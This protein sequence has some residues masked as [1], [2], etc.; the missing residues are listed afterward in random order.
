MSKYQLKSKLN[1]QIKREVFPAS[2]HVI[3]PR[4][5]KANQSFLSPCALSPSNGG[6]VEKRLLI[7]TNFMNFFN[8]STHRFAFFI[9][10]F[11]STHVLGCAA[12]F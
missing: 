5:L 3:L 6:T 7:R 1:V 12:K 11:H 4:T 8:F 2:L 9:A 10:L